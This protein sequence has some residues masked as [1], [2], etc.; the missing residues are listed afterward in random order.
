MVPPFGASAST[1]ISSGLEPASR[2]METFCV[3]MMFSTTASCWFT[4]IGYNAVYLPTYSMR[5][6]LASK[7]PVRRRTRSCRMPG[8]RTSN[9][10]DSP[11]SRSCSISPLNSIGS[12]LGPCGR[13]S[14]LP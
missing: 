7:A 5:S 14:T 6:M 9:G 10:S 12:P 11:A 13:T 8:K 4:L 2:P 3:A 1:A